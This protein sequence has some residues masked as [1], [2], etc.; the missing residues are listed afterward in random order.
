MTQKTTLITGANR[1]LGLAFVKK[2]AS[3]NWHVLACC[4]APDSASELL[5]LASEH[6]NIQIEEL[7]INEQTQ[8]DALAKKHEDQPIDLLINNAGVSG[9]RGVTVGNIDRENFVHLFKTNCLGQLKLSEAL[10]PNLEKS[11]DK[12]ILV[13]SSRMAS[14]SDNSSGQSYAYRASKVALNA[15]MRSFAI[16]VQAKGIKVML[17]HPGWVK[18]NMGGDDALVT[19]TQSVAGMLSVLEKNIDNAHAETVWRFDGDTIEW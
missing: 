2:L 6:S 13:I 14:I 18:T 9:N 16:D 3:D 15:V 4:R 11:T 8:I 12:H 19:P 7:D 10:L 1:G 5:K 17:M